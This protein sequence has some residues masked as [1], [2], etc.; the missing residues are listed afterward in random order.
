H[1]VNDGYPYL[2]RE[3]NL[4]ADKSDIVKPLSMSLKNYPNPFNPE[5]TISFNLPMAS[6]VELSIYNIKGQ[7]VE[8]VINRPMEA[9]QHKIVWNGN[10]VSSGLYFYKLTTPEGSLI[11][12]MMLLK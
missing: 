6:E 8:R 12:K 4:S 10:D 3:I 1:S 11:N 7:L 5:T 2:C 9:G